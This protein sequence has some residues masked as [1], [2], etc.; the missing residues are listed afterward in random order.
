[1]FRIFLLELVG[2][3][4]LIGAQLLCVAGRSKR[5]GVEGLVWAITWMNRPGARKHGKRAKVRN[6]V[7]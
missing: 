5:T 6:R 2:V 4:L 3:N 7:E 1:M